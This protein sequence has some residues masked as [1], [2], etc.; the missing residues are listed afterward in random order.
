MKSRDKIIEFLKIYLK[1]D[2][3]EDYCINGIQVE[4]KEEISKIVLGVSSSKRL[5]ESAI[6]LDAD[7]I[8]VHHGLFWKSDSPFKITGWMKERI[9]LLIK[10]DINL[11]AFH[12]PL[13]AHPEIGNN[14]EICR[15][16][17]LDVIDKFS[18]GFFAQTK[19]KIKFDKFENKVNKKIGTTAVSF[20]YSKKD[21]EKLLV[22]SGG[23]GKYFE[24]AAKLGADTFI[25]GN[26]DEHMIRI[27]EEIELNLLNIGHYNSEKYG[28]QALGKLIEKEFSVSTTFVDIPNII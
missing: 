8:L 14:K 11:A 2:E 12:L 23:S 10:N 13:D 6:E 9:S 21:V 24:D 28:I 16:L 4:G 1:A 7:M 20:P 22:I 15:I 19:K 25:T 5:F 18:V 17:E 3:F 26:L 27:A